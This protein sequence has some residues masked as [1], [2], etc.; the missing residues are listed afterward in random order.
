MELIKRLF[1]KRTRIIIRTP[2]GAGYDLE[3][4]VKG[5]EETIKHHP[6]LD[7]QVVLQWRDY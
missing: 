7:F 3:E 1:R 5:L 6:N 4:V 2:Y